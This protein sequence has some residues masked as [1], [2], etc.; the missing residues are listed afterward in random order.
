MTLDPWWSSSLSFFRLFVGVTDLTLHF[1]F[2]EPQ[3]SPERGGLLQVV[4]K[5]RL[6]NR[7]F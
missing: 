1:G 6:L 4:A 7:G 3:K 2:G 5:F